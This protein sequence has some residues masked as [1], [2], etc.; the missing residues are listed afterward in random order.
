MRIDDPIIEGNLNLSGDDV[1][2]NSPSGSISD[3]TSTRITETSALILKENIQP[4][5]SQL[6]FLSR[7]NL[8]SCNWKEDNREDIGLI[9]EE[10]KEIYP[11]LVKNDKNNEAIGINYSKL[12]A[13]LINTVKELSNK[14]KNLE[15]NI[16][17]PL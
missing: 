17:N 14:V 9:A 5:E 10:V 7:L 1:V 8:V 3:L 6:N 13:I 11:Q 16:N 15:Q 4:L 12:T 2:I